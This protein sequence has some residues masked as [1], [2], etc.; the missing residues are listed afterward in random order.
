MLFFC[1]KIKSDINDET[2]GISSLV[3]KGCNGDKGFLLNIA[4]N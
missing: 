4:Y 2:I 3:L 1:N